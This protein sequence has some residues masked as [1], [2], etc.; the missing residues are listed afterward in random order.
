MNSPPLVFPHSSRAEPSAVF[1]TPR[2]LR[3]L[4]SSAERFAT[5]GSLPH[6]KTKVTQFFSEAPTFC[7]CIVNKLIRSSP[8]PH[9]VDALLQD[10]EVERVK[11]HLD[12][13][14]ELS[15]QLKD[16]HFGLAQLSAKLFPGAPTADCPDFDTLFE[17]NRRQLTGLR[18]NTLII[19][20]ILIGDSLTDLKSAL[21][22][23]Q[24]RPR[25][26]YRRRT[27][28]RSASSSKSALRI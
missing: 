27:F 28:W 3:T 10:S 22:F 5:L 23:A 11:Q 19:D 14:A 21:A 20:S 2:E 26:A 6:Q 4:E 12:E 24:C 25:W 15:D 18:S 9:S 1:Q 17:T 7:D 13:T 16:E 8:P